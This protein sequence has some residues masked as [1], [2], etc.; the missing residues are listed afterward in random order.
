LLPPVRRGVTALVASR[1]APVV[2]D[3]VIEAT[4]VEVEAPRL[5]SGWTKE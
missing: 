5:P 3:D 1:F 2:D 4:A